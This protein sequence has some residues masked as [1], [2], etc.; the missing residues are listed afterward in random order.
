M[1]PGGLGEYVRPTTPPV[2]EMDSIPVAEAAGTPAQPWLLRSELDGKEIP[3]GKNSTVGSTKAGSTKGTDV[4]S[5]NATEG[6]YEL[7]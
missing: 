6:R 3:S 7:P 2:P 4:A 1:K 5:T